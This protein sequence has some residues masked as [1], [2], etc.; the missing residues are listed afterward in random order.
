MSVAIGRHDLEDALGQV[1]HRDIVGATT[2]VV[3]GDLLVFFLL[4]A[5]SKGRRGRLVDNA[6]DFQSGDTSCILGSLT[7]AVVKV[8]WH[9]ND[10][11]I[12][13]F[14]KVGFS[15]GLELLENHRGDFRRC[16]P[17]LTNLDVNA[18]VVT[19]ADF[20]RY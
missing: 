5:V 13:R 3:D 12:D 19:L 10:G 15:V 16:D 4:K 18:A 1:E 14:A 8:S 17:A 11:L 20:V 9:G 6:K 7:L 2:K